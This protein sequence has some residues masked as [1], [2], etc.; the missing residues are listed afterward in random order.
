MTITSASAA[1]TRALDQF[2]LT[3]DH[4]ALPA[5]FIDQIQHPYSAPIVCFG[6]DE[7][8]APYMTR[9]LRPEA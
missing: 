2:P 7:I 6:A 8:V 4:Q 1:I 5:V 3:S 9:T